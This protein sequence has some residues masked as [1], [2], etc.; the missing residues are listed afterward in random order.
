MPFERA[1]DLLREKQHLGSNRKPPRCVAAIL[2]DAGEEY[3]TA[4]R[5]GDK[6]TAWLEMFEKHLRVEDLNARA[7]P[8]FTIGPHAQNLA[9]LTSRRA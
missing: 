1:S 2:K 9:A 8:C 5:I 3:V 4:H 7:D 6:S